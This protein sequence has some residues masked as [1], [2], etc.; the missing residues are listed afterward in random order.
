MDFSFL[1]TLCGPL[2]L[3]GLIECP[4]DAYVF[5]KDARKTILMHNLDISYKFFA[6]ECNSVQDV[7]KYEVS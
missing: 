7:Q 3:S 4:G 2:F 5:L 1:V 6:V